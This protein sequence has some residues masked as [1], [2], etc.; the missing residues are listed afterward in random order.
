MAI[1]AFRFFADLL[2]QPG[3]DLLSCIVSETG[4]FKQCRSSFVFFEIF[5]G[6]VRYLR[7]IQIQRIERPL[8]EQLC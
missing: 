4:V 2:F 6:A 3:R 5:T 7:I 8:A 1:N